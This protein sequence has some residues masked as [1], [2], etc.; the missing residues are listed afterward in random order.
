MKLGV[1]IGGA[2]LELVDEEKGTTEVSYLK[3]ARKGTC[4]KDRNQ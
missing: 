1:F 3:L 2:V 4:T